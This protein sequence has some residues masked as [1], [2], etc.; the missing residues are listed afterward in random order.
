MLSP[1]FC[2]ETGVEAHQEGVIRCLLKDVLFCLDPV[3]VLEEEHTKDTSEC[4]SEIF[5]T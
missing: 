1:A 5:I 4:Q 2:L 3:D